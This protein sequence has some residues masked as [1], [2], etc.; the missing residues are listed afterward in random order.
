[1]SDEKPAIADSAVISACDR[2]FQLKV[3]LRSHDPLAAF[4]LST[5]SVD[6]KGFQD[7]FGYFKRG[8][9]R[10]LALRF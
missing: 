5:Q 3:S 10:V 7:N 1:M 9:L 4:S 8:E 6:I 2:A